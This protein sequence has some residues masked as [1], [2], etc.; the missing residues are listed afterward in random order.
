M[1]DECR[2]SPPRKPAAAK[3]KAL[4]QAAPRPAAGGVPRRGYEEWWYEPDVYP[5][6]RPGR[7]YDDPRPGWRGWYGY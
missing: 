7:F 6:R 4:A 5:A 2:P 3:P 1:T